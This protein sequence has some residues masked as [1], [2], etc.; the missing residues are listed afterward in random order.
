MASSSSSADL[1]RPT[2]T[3]DW[4][5]KLARFGY[6]AKGVVYAAVGVL[7]VQAA[8]GSGGQTTG[9]RGAIQQIGQQPFGRVMLG[10]IAVGLLG[11]VV[12]RFTQAIKDPEDKGDDAKGI[13][14]RIGIAVSGFTYTLLSLAAAQQALG[15]GGGGGG[16]NSKDAWSAKLLAQPYGQWLL[17]AVGI[18]VIGVGLYQFK[19]AY[20][21]S[22][23]KDYSGEM[24]ARQKRWAKFI[25]QFGLA[26]RG[27][28]F[29]IIG[30]FV[31][32]AAY[33]ADPSET[34]G[35]GGALQTLAEQ[36][37][38]PWLLGAVALGFVAYGLYCLSRARYRVF[39]TE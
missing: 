4:I 30:G 10:L 25:G 31:T 7:A 17:G 3:G 2:D 35:L 26:A 37:Y 39:E 29:C 15:M 16:G 11:Y 24:G 27:V 33:Q 12:W 28:T 20:E 38:G 34:R 36:P 8:F 18:I 14:K 21:A 13:G 5:E 1:S 19:R 23:M 6:A 32:I 9:S 22:F